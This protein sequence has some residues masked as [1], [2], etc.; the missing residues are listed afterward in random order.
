MSN[1]S[2][3]LYKAARMANNIDALEH[4]KRWRRRAKNILLVLVLF[5]MMMMMM[6]QLAQAVPFGVTI[7]NISVSYDAPKVTDNSQCNIEALR[8]GVP[9]TLTYTIPLGMDVNAPQL[10]LLNDSLPSVSEIKRMLGTNVEKDELISLSI[11]SWQVCG[12][13]GVGGC[14]V[15]GGIENALGQRRWYDGRVIIYFQKGPYLCCIDKQRIRS[16]HSESEVRGEME[17]FNESLKTLKVD[18]T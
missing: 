5:C 3:H 2:R 6:G 11:G 7:G 14:I 18:I 13:T 15:S 9:E 4:P 10:Y 16:T 8:K 12:Q 17:K 1:P